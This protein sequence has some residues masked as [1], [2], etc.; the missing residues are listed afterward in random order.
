MKLKI[1]PHIIAKPVITVADIQPIGSNTVKV[2][3]T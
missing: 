3:D 2:N 1:S